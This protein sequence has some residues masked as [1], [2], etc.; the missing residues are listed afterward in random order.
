MC[1][2]DANMGPVNKGWQKIVKSTRKKTKTVVSPRIVKKL[3]K[4][5]KDKNVREYRLPFGI[6]QITR[7]VI[8][9]VA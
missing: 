2:L 9:P 3:K 8:G 4:A 7:G 6:A 5:A 1:I